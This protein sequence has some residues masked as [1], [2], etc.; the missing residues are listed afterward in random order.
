VSIPLFPKAPQKFP[1]AGIAGKL[2]IE[3]QKVNK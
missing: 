2:H 3:V 1:F